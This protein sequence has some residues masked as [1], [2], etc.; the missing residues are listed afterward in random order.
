MCDNRDR[1]TNTECMK[2]DNHRSR[3]GGID[4]WTGSWRHWL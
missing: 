2:I 1:R 4:P 3:H